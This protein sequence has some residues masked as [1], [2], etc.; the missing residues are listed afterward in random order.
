MQR[1]THRKQQ[2]IIKRWYHPPSL[3]NWCFVHL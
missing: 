2:K 3:T 1:L